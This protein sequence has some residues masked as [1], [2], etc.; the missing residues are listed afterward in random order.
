M[1]LNSKIAALALGLSAFSIA[2]AD[3]SPAPY[4]GANLGIITVDAGTDLDF[5][6][7][8]GHIGAQLNEHFAVEARAATGLSDDKGIDLDSYVGVLAKGMLPLNNQL[9]LYGV[10]GYSRVEISNYWYSASDTGLTLG[11]GASYAVDRTTSFAAEFARLQEDVTAL[12]LSG[13]IKF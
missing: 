1:K 3:A 4:A 11:V 8:G 6:A 12:T 13:S 5:L 2:Q 9:S 10:V 7:A